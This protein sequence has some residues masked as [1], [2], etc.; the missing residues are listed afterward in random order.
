LQ[1]LKGLRDEFVSVHVGAVCHRQVTLASARLLQKGDS[2]GYQ[3][4]V[5]T[6]RRLHL[7]CVGAGLT[8]FVAVAGRDRGYVGFVLALVMPSGTVAFLFTDIQGSTARWEAD[9][10]GMRAALAG[11]E[12]LLEEGR[13]VTRWGGLRVDG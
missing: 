11:H 6:G 1:S 5:I 12:T 4:P 13:C 9:P 2:T 3:V 10:V 7:R 8:E